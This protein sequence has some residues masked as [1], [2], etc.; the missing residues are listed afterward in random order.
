MA[1]PLVLYILMILALMG[2][3]I[4]EHITISTLSLPIFPALTVLTI[5]LP[6]LSTLTTFFTPFLFMNS[7]S[8]ATITTRDNDNMDINHRTRTRTQT[9]RNITSI[10]TGLRRTTTTITLSWLTNVLQLILTTVLATLLAQP[11]SSSSSQGS[12]SLTDCLLSGKW[13]ALWRAHDAPAIRAIQDALSCCGFRSTR[14]MAWP[15]P[16][17]GGD[18]PGARACEVQFGRRD[19]CLPLWEGQLRRALAGDIGVVLCVGLLQVL[20]LVGSAKGVKKGFGVAGVMESLMSVFAGGSRGKRP[21][22][23]EGRRPLLAAAPEGDRDIEGGRVVETGYRDNVDEDDADYE[24]ADR[25]VEREQGREPVRYG[26]IGEGPRVEPAHHDP[27]AGVQR[28]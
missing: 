19:A 13:R 2:V 3:A 25:E 11:L 1:L 14:D 18:G 12:S 4:Y 10:P 27:W 9:H 6:L 28:A 22:G 23:S 8:H 24:D 5:L 17:R 16:S 21:N 15:F 20:V 7:N 26:A